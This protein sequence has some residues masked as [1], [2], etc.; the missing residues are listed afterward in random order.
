MS[1]RGDPG[2][3]F[4]AEPSEQFPNIG[5]RRVRRERRVL[6]KGTVPRPAMRRVAEGWAS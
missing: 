5:A 6:E 2:A 4:L 3:V 1:R